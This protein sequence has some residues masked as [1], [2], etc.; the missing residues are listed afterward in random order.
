MRAADLLAGT[1]DA[2]F[3]IDD[4]GHIVGWNAAAER[5]LGLRCR[6]VVGRPCHEI[7]ACRDLRGAALQPAACPLFEAVRTGR[8]AGAMDL[9]A[10]HR[11]G[12]GVEVSASLILLP[13]GCGA[14]AVGLLRPSACGVALE[15]PPAA[16]GSDR[17]PPAVDRDGPEPAPDLA[18]ALDRLLLVTGADAAELFLTAPPNGQLVLAAHRGRAP[19]AF[20]Q[21]V[22][23]DRGQGFPGIVAQSGEPL[24]SLDLAHDERYLRERVKHQGFRSYLCVP[25][26]GASGY[27]GSLHIASRRP[28]GAIAAHGPFLTHVAAHLATC[29]EHHRLQTAASLARQSFDPAADAGVNLRRI[30]DGALSTLVEA[31]SADCG[32]LLLH[33][34]V[35]GSLQLVSERDLPPRLQR[36]LARACEPAA[37]PAVAERRCVITSDSTA[38]QLPLCRAVQRDLATALCLP[39]VAAGQSLGVAL[40]G[41]SHREALPTRHL[42]FLH[43]AVDQVAVALHNALVALREE[44]DARLRSGAE[45]AV[46]TDA[47]AS[48]TD[49]P[50]RR[51][52][53][54]AT[55]QVARAPFLDLR[56]LG[57]FALS[58]DGRLVPP[59]RFARRRALTLLKILLTRYGKQV[60]REE[61]MEL[62]WPEADPRSGNALL[63]VVVHYLRRGLEPNAPADRPSSFVLTSGDYYTFSTASP[64]RLDSQEFLEAVRQAT[65]LESRGQPREALGLYRRAMVLYAGDFLEDELYSDWCA[66]E[67]EYL[68]ESFLTVLRRAACLHLAQRD[69]EAAVACYRRA[70]LTDAT[71]ED[72]HRALI[73]AL[74][75]A[76]RRDEA[77]R[78]YRE[79][80]AVLERELGVA[81]MPE[82]E[83]LRRAI[84]A[85]ADPPPARA[86]S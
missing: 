54:A 74:W 14:R 60:H 48:P 85:N 53:E 20:R 13:P 56:C 46:G 67:R 42:S 17:G 55:A 78:Q 65:R 28:G 26:W 1:G 69:V 84:A 32:A 68:R 52:S 23:F 12:R 16:N 25:V 44:Q 3:A 76:G 62:L 51:E 31:A 37:C 10:H 15:P 29:L 70:L 36:T 39:L 86:P 58:S 64:H 43:A 79:C 5:L 24:V 81:P 21:I 19:R 8:P 83:A 80:R 27:L 61:L 50:P 49:S 71:L 4:A 18:S 82:T 75:R 63:H 11:G 35:A 22:C 73:E 72:V 33:D 45:G 30:A 59:E 57:P 7:L 2:G 34:G 41:F 77:L 9:V 6:D 38:A 66:L 47:P 40:L